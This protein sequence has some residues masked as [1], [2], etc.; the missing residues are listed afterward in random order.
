MVSQVK[1]IVKNDYIFSLFQ[2]IINILTG[3]ITIS[4]INRYLGT[5]LKGEY[6]Y[7][8]LLFLKN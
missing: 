6:E 4:L 5:S 8:L 7:I 1:K 2:K 3:I